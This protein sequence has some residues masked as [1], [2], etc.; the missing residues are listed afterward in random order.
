MLLAPK[1]ERLTSFSP[2]RI[3]NGAQNIR[4]THRSGRPQF[5]V[6][7]DF[8]LDMKQKYCYFKHV[9]PEEEVA[10][11]ARVVV[12]LDRSSMHRRITRTD[13]SCYFRLTDDRHD[14]ACVYE[15]R[16]YPTNDSW[17][18]YKSTTAMAA[19]TRDGVELAFH[20]STSNTND[21]KFSK[22]RNGKP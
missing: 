21:R 18:V 2:C 4:V 15:G 22:A 14:S 17:Q 13:S 11:S 16:S 1:S 5:T 3:E 8:L 10:K 7:S 9:N 19:E 6:L 12:R 20:N